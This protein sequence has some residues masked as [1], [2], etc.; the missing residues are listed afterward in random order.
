MDELANRLW[1]AGDGGVYGELVGIFDR[2]RALEASAEVWALSSLFD[3]LRDASADLRVN[4]SGLRGDTT[5]PQYTLLDALADAADRQN[6]RLTPEQ[7][8]QR[9]QIPP[10]PD[11]TVMYPSF[12]A[13]LVVDQ[14]LITRTEAGMLD[15][16]GTLGQ[17]DFK[18]LGDSA[19]DVADDRFP[20]QGPEDGHNDA[21][22]HAYFNALM[23]R[24][25]GE[26]WAR[27][28][29]NAHEALPGNMVDREAMDLFNNEVGRQI[30][31]ENPDASD[32]EL[33]DLVEQAIRDGDMVVIPPG[34]G[35]AYSDQIAP[36]ETGD[37]SMPP[38]EPAEDDLPDSD[39]S[40]GGP[41]SGDRSRDYD[42]SGGGSW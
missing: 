2:A 40:A 5:T 15:E 18:E 42:P 11:G 9:Y 39:A 28:Y 13:S 6:E 37:A 33:A 10:D 38:Q 4:A 36:G 1:T 20:D 23:V 34:G 24:E 3:W 19:Y 25:Y 14:R 31:V 26:D 22:R 29:A 27:R 8:L 12:P 35:I 41:G 17:I 21:F 16:L 30:A 32:E 7:I